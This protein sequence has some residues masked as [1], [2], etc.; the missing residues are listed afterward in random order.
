MK[1]DFV[2]EEWLARLFDDAALM[3]LLDGRKIFPASANR[4]VKV[5]S[6]EYLMRYDREEEWLNVV[7][8]QLDLFVRGIRNAAQ[9]ERR[10]RLLTHHDTS[11][12]LGDERVWFQFRD[13]RSIDF[14]SDPGVV[15]RALDFECQSVREKYVPQGA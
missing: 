4:P 13:A 5:P 15:H 10:L 9:V 12:E 7:G 11:Q 8:F 3:S 14:P 6:V 1:W 2:V